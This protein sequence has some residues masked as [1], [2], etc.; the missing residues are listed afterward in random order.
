MKSP[1]HY[2]RAG[3]GAAIIN[4]RGLVLAL[5]RTDFP[6]SWQL[7]QGGLKATETPLEAMFREVKEETGIP[8]SKLDLLDTYPDPLAYELPEEAWSRKTGRGQ[9]GYWF[10]L[11]FR[12]ADDDI[13]LG[14]SRE[15]NRWK[16][17]PFRRLTSQV[18]DFRKPV[19]RKLNERFKPH[20]SE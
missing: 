11:R 4:P 16:W 6:G 10:L 18:V 2:F 9:V 14:H 8:Q 7:P 3:S 12:G 1:A 17:I 13:D 20:F 19:Y 15:F 5:E